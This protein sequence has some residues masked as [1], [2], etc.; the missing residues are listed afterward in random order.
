LPRAIGRFAEPRPGSSR[1]VHH[2]P[3]P[4]A[5]RPAAARP[6]S[7]PSDPDGSPPA[8]PPGR[9]Q[10]LART[11]NPVNASYEDVLGSGHPQ[12]VLIQASPA[13]QQRATGQRGQ[14]A[15]DQTGDLID[16]IRQQV[17]ELWNADSVRLTER[18][19]A[20][21]DDQAAKIVAAAELEAAEI[22][23][24]AAERAAA[25]LTTAEQEATQMREAAVKMT[26]ELGGVAAYITENLPLASPATKSAT[27]PATAPTAARP[28]AETAARAQPDATET[29]AKP[30]KPA[31][32]PPTGPAARPGVSPRRT[33]KARPA[34]KSKSRQVSAWHKM[35]AALIV[36][37]LIG[38][39][40]A[41]TEMGLHGLSF[42]VFRNAGAGAGN[43]RNL[44]ENQGPGQ[45]D[46]P[47]AHHK[48]NAGKPGDKAGQSK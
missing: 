13:S 46:A 20:E 15:V 34:T 26:T 14:L 7:M 11:A 33:P 28:A 23:K 9:M 22:R 25:T 27:K 42:F 2:D 43:S 44:N 10:R 16:P 17:E 30:A 36:L 45:P 5:A 32:R 19:L 21:A 12:A 41:V 18:M 37:F 40:S 38:V 39:T 4:Q 6:G 31:A 35:V 48:A 24:S 1:A 3:Y 29:I 8:T 47:G